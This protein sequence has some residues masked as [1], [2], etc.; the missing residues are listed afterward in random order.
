[1][2]LVGGSSSSTTMNT[3]GSHGVFNDQKLFCIDTP[4]VFDST[5]QD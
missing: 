4:G 2:F 3:F 5:G 1:M